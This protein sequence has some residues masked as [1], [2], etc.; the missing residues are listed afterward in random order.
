MVPDGLP[1]KPRSLEQLDGTEPLADATVLDFDPRRRRNDQTSWYCRCGADLAF[2]A[3][4]CAVSVAGTSPPYDPL[5]MLATALAA[6]F[7]GSPSSFS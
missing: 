5:S 6:P 1:F 2:S 3:A 7:P 4:C